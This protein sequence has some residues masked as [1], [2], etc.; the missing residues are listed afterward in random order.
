MF[1]APRS[2]G[3][4]RYLLAKHAWLEQQPGIRHSLVVPGA[5]DG[6]DGQGLMT[7]ASPRIPLGNGYRWPL[8]SRR[9]RQ[10]IVA[11]AP[12]LIE[13]GD[14]Y[15]PAWQAQA[16]ARRLQVP[17]VGFCHSDLMG[18]AQAR[19]GACTRAGIARYMHALYTRFD[20][21]LAPSRH[22][23]RG[24]GE[25]GLQRVVQQPLGVDLELFH[26]D[27][28]D[29]RLRSQLGLAPDTRL[30]I[31]AGRF[32]REKNIPVLVEAFERLGAGYHL[33]LVGA[34]QA[35]RRHRGQR[36]VTVM[37]FLGEGEPL[38]RLIASADAFVHAGDRETF[39]LVALEAMACGLP[40]IAPE[41]GAMGELVDGTVGYQVPARQPG[42][43]A[44]AVTALYEGDRRERLAGQ[45]RERAAHYSWARVLG[46][47]LE[48]YRGIVGA[49]HVP[50]NGVAQ[51]ALG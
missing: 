51:R 7:V 46:Q 27:R 50:T 48:L 31:Y 18:L 44:E 1:F 32:S 5:T 23:C 39:G 14:P 26:P 2:G 37:S 35:T 13:A 41:R 40:V 17:V 47:Q 8:R 43:L 33:L 3:V 49:A 16:A 6:S 4:K 10:R 29:P 24:L 30:L 34:S 36:N 42:T 19:A 22:M 25:L 15:G 11:Q 45:A 38:A 20:L 28:R 21:V 12:D 9:W